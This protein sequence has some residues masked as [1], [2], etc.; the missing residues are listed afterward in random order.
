MEKEQAVYTFFF[1]TG[2]QL[3]RKQARG[4]LEPQNSLS[5]TTLVLKFTSGAYF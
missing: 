1:Y 2:Q 4:P 3:F 5:T